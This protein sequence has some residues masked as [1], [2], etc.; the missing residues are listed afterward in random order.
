V[1]F[2]NFISESLV[3]FLSITVL[4]IIGVSSVQDEAEHIKTKV[5]EYKSV[6]D[7]FIEYIS[8]I[9][10]LRSLCNN[11]NS[12]ASEV[13]S[14]CKDQECIELIKMD[15]KQ[16]ASYCATQFSQLKSAGQLIQA[17]QQDFLKSLADKSFSN[18]PVAIDDFKMRIQNLIDKTN[19]TKIL[20][21]D[22]SEMFQSAYNQLIQYENIKSLE[23][24]RF[25]HALRVECST[26]K[27]KI[28]MLR[29]YLILLSVKDG[30]YFS[31]YDLNQ[32]LSAYK[33][34][35]NALKPECNVNFAEL[36]EMKKIVL[37]QFGSDTMSFY[38]WA[39]D[40]CSKAKNPHYA[41]ICSSI[42]G[43]TFGFNIYTLQILN[44]VD[45]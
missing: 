3:I 5:S 30:D 44:E 43:G 6:I 39:T 25:A 8:Q 19:N 14:I 26:L 7:S 28:S 16:R 20:V 13:N 33:N 41:D 17:K 21:Q 29:N 4:P 11:L 36:D 12:S 2:K 10:K 1:R 23:E 15:L 18:F 38:K 42:Q 45:K 22:I 27:S 40:K 34:L 32:K 35:A 37:N 9:N 24:L 31:L